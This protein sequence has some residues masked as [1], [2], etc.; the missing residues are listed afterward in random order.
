[1]LIT[2][3]Q[4]TNMPIAKISCR[5]LGISI[6]LS[7]DQTTRLQIFVNKINGCYYEETDNHMQL[8]EK[9]FI[10]DLEKQAILSYNLTDKQLIEELVAIEKVKAMSEPSA[11]LICKKDFQIMFNF[12]MTS[13]KNNLNLM[14]CN[15]KILV[16]LNL[17]L[18]LKDFFLY[19]IDPN[20]PESK[21]VEGNFQILFFVY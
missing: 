16:V 17:F 14:I 8:I 6:S 21:E 7:P 11:Y 9:T 10:G 2:I 19:T 4:L 15:M 13:T 3:D 1:M 20:I 18:R 12:E 5:N